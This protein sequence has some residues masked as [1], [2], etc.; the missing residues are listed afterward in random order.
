MKILHFRLFLH[1]IKYTSNIQ[2][3]GVGFSF[4]PFFT[5]YLDAWYYL[6]VTLNLKMTNCIYISCIF[7]DVN[8]PNFND[9]KILTPN[10]K[11]ENHVWS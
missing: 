6:D 1:S 7:K 8:V 9:I 2:T 3:F 5:F 10:Q 11:Y 4:F